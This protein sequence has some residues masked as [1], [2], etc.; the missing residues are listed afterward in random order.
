LLSVDVGVRLSL[1]VLQPHLGQF[2]AVGL[3]LVMVDKL[4][5]MSCLV[6]CLLYYVVD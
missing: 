4:G 1:L 6:G 5:V 2:G 3:W